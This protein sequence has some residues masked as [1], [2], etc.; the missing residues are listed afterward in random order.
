MNMKKY[1]VPLMVFGTA[2]AA[3]GIFGYESHSG[4][5][6]W[7]GWS[8]DHKIEICFGMALAVFGALL[9]KD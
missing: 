2:L 9:R 7:S 8:L 5:F 3:F 1:A 6:G 4:P